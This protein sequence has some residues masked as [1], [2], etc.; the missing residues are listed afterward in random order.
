MQPTK[1]VWADTT[2]SATQL[3]LVEEFKVEPIRS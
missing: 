1:K 3:A 2:P